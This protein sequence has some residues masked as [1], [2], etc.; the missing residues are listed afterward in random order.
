[1]K[2]RSNNKYRIAICGKSRAGKD[3]VASRLTDRFHDKGMYVSKHAF[4]DGIKDLYKQH[5]GKIPVDAKP[6][7]AYITI[8]ETFRSIYP[9][10]WVDKLRQRVDESYQWDVVMVTDLRRKNEEAYL[11]E[12]GFTI[13]KVDAPDEVRVARAARLGEVLEVDNDGD[14]EVDKIEY[15]ILVD[16]SSTIS[17]ETITKLYSELVGSK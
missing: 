13:I 14:A 3:L 5:F 12:A 17:E 4:A 15:D 16:S 11:R 6:R 1:M 9:D 2:I 10:V 7:D 8:G